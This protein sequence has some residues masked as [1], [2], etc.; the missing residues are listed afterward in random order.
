M[1]AHELPVRVYYQ[2]TDAAGIVYH[3]NY[4]K[5]AERGRT[6][7]LRDLGFDHS[8]LAQAHGMVFAVARC[9][10]DFLRPARLDELL[11]VRTAV[12]GVGGA[13]VEMR[14]LIHRDGTPMARLEVTLAVL[15]ARA[16]RP[17]RLP[18]IV[19]RAFNACVLGDDLPVPINRLAT[20][21]DP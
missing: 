11:H 5:F 8:K 9:C 18:E 13:R 12:A 16:L 7:M 1:P 4:L 3:A 2:D 14:Q 6:E 21:S 17:T 15:D 10:I 20:G 19:R